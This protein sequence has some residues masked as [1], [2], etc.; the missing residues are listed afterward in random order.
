MKKTNDTKKVLLCAVATAVLL[1]GVYMILPGFTRLTSVYISDY[2][3]SDDGSEMTINVSVTSSVG[4]VRKVAVHQQESGKLCL[5]CYAAFGGINGSIGAK[6]EHTVKLDK[7]T[8][9]IAL[10]KNNN[11]YEEVLRK[12]ENGNWQRA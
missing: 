7:D 6:S 1:F 10:Y 12:D 2:S 9:V 4:F 11:C 8:E 3:L 5:D